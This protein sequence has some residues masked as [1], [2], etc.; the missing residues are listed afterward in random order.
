MTCLATEQSSTKLTEIVGLKSQNFFVYFIAL[1][2]E[3]Q[4][5]TDG[6]QK[7][8]TKRCHNHNL[9]Q[10]VLQTRPVAQPR[11]SIL[12]PRNT[13]T[14]R[15]S[16]EDFHPPSLRTPWPRRRRRGKRPTSLLETESRLHQRNRHLLPKPAPHGTVQGRFRGSGRKR[17]ISLHFH[18]WHVLAASMGTTRVLFQP[19]LSCMREH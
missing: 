16:H 10:N 19:I 4:R 15:P 18:H 8:A 2:I 5:E 14:H 7:C 13:T 6:S 9:L 11:P 3:I 1:V 17:W 12:L